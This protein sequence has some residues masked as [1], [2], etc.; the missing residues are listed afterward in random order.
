[1]IVRG[2]D[3]LESRVM[4]LCKGTHWLLIVRVGLEEGLISPMRD[5]VL[6]VRLSVFY[7]LGP[8]SMLDVPFGFSG[9][10]SRWIDISLRCW[11]VGEHAEARRVGTLWVTLYLG[12]I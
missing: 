8:R 4:V 1:M 12:W 11:I 6:I 7:S 3:D 10:D 5:G 2:I 9:V